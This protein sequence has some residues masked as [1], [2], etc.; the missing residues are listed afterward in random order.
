MSA[1]E[2]TSHIRNELRA[3]I[4]LA[5]ERLCQEWVVAQAYKSKLPFAPQAVGSHWSRQ[6]QI[7]VIAINHEARKVLLGECKW[8]TNRVNRQVVRDLIETKGA[9][10]R[11]ELPDGDRWHFYYVVFASDADGRLDAEKLKDRVPFELDGAA[12]MFCGPPPLRL[13]IVDGLKK[14]GKKFSAVKFELFEFR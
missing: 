10:L 6:V 1:E 3:F 4:G 9:N 7:D 2:T 12:M 14:M 11:Q 5:F 13:A 8:G